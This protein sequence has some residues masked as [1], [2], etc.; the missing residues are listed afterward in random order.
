MTKFR[1]ITQHYITVIS[2]LA[3]AMLFWALGLGHIATLILGAYSLLVFVVCDDAKNALVPLLTVAFFLNSFKDSKVYVFYIIAASLFVVGAIYYLVKMLAIRKAK[4]TKGKMFYAMIAYAVA[5]FFGGLIGHFNIVVS[6]ILLGFCL[7]IYFCYF[8]LLNFSENLK[9]AVRWFFIIVSI[10]LFVQLIISHTG[11][12]DFAWSLVHRNVLEIGVQNINVAS[13]YVM[14][15]MIASLWL[16][17]ENKKYDVYYALAAF[18]QYLLIF[19]LYSR[20]TTLTATIALIACGIY[21]FVKS[22]NKKRFSFWAIGLVVVIA[23]LSAI[24]WSMINDIVQSYT[25]RLAGG[26]GRETLWP[27]CFEK[28]KENP[29]FGIGFISAEPVPCV[30]TPSVVM[31]H[32][33]ILQY[34]TSTGIVGTA[35]MMYFFVVKYRVV[36]ND[37]KKFDWFGAIMVVGVALIG[38]TDQSQTIDI[39]MISISL[40][41]VA[42]CEIL[43]KQKAPTQQDKIIE[44]S[45]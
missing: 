13:I 29:W 8:I 30:S 43:N 9:D 1:E 44:E 31:A 36:F 39:F 25:A 40:G 16:A 35:I 38:I 17:Y 7:A 11:Q 20:M 41:L 3:V 23:L 34:L 21:V 22:E 2:L 33:T 37:F 12:G 28:F 27:W 15:G 24:F 4:A 32:N 26:N 14:L 6:L 42:L 5:V 10:E 19:F 18:A 45:N